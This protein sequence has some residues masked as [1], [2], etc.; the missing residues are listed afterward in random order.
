[1]TELSSC[2]RE[3][4]AAKPKIFTTWLFRKIGCQP[5][6]EPPSVPISFYVTYRSDEWYYVL[7]QTE[8]LKGK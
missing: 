4:V 2:N 1:M 7:S 3:H 6:L 5:V 8:K